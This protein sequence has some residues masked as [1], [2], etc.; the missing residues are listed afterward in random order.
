MRPCGEC[1]CILKYNKTHI[2]CWVIYDWVAEKWSCVLNQ[3]NDW[4][5]KL[6][7]MP[8]QNPP[9]ALRQSTV[10]HSVDNWVWFTLFQRTV[11]ELL[12]IIAFP[13]R[14]WGLSV[15][16]TDMSFQGKKMYQIG[17]PDESWQTN[18]KQTEI[19][20]SDLRAVS[21]SDWQVLQVTPCQVTE[22]NDCYR[23]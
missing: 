8:F 10:H 12:G 5:L 7:V 4:K 20:L 1:I 21:H 9:M 14:A 22:G 15:I 11:A 19:R 3:L 6:E 18:Q 2:R 17:S 23:S 13:H 16:L